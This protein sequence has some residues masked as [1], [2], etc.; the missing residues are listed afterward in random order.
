M[1]V[2]PERSRIGL[3]SGV[4]LTVACALSAA[5]AEP[6]QPAAS[7]ISVQVKSGVLAVDFM[8]LTI[9]A[10]QG[11]VCKPNLVIQ[12][13]NGDTSAI[14]DS[15]ISLRKS[16]DWCAVRALCA[17]SDKVR[18]DYG[19][20]GCKIKTYV[21]ARCGGAGFGYTAGPPTQGDSWPEAVAVVSVSK[22]F[23]G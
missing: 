13:R 19:V 11:R 17:V 14:P 16:R 9:H 15:G 2:W 10:R 7:T 12:V 8:G 20:H 21:P 22:I 6:Q 4:S 5:P 23:R 1:R 18:V 3:A